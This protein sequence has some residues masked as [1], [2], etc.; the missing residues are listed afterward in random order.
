MQQTRSLGICYSIVWVWIWCLVF[1][2][3]TDLVRQGVNNSVLLNYRSGT[4]RK[5]FRDL[6]PKP[7]Y[8]DLGL[9]PC[10]LDLGLLLDKNNINSLRFDNGYEIVNCL[11]RFGLKANPWPKF[12]PNP[13]LRHQN[14]NQIQI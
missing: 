5:I 12:K 1:E 14:Q 13:K 6:G 2:F 9:K 11:C 3:I 10:C 7:C 4:S 8:L